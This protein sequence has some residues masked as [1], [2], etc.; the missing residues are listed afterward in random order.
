MKNFRILVVAAT[1]AATFGT[2]SIAGETIKPL[3]P[4][5]STQTAGEF[6]FLANGTLGVWTLV[7]GALVLVAVLNNTSGT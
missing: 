2:A 7:G 4:V 6:G 5:K 1:L 3:K